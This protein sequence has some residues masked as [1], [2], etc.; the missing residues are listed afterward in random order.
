MPW[1]EKIENVTPISHRYDFF[2][3]I[4]DLL[5]KL[6]RAEDAVVLVNKTSESALPPSQKQLLL[7]WIQIESKTVNISDA[8]RTCEEVSGTLGSHAEYYITREIALCADKIEHYPLSFKLWKE[9]TTSQ[10]FNPDT[11]SLLRAA[12]NTKEYQ[13]II[14]FCTQLRKNEIHERNGYRNEIQA[15]IECHEFNEALNLMVAWLNHKTEDKEMRMNL[16]LLA[17]EIGNEQYIEGDPDKLPAINEVPN[18]EY[19]T[20]VIQSLRQSGNAR[21]AIVYAYE[22][23]RKFPDEMAARHILISTVI[24]SDQ[25][26]TILEKPKEVNL[27]SAVI[28]KA[29]DSDESRAHIIEEGPSPSM[30]RNEYSP[31]HEISKSLLKKKTSDTILLRGTEW[32]ILEIHNKYAYRVSN[33]LKNFNMDFPGNPLL[34]EFKVPTQ[35]DSSTEPQEA[36]GEIR[37]FMQNED[38]RQKTLENLYQKGSLPIVAF[39]QM[40]GKSVLETM[41]YYAASPN[42]NI[43]VSNVSFSYDIALKALSRGCKIVLDETAIATLFMLGLYK[44]LG[45][46]P[47]ELIIPETLVH[48]IRRVAK[49]AAFKRRSSLFLGISNGN[50][51][52]QRV[53]P[54]QHANWINSLEELLVSLQQ[55]CTLEGGKSLLS[56]EPATRKGLIQAFGPANADAIA[57]ASQTGAIYWTDDLLSRALASA[58][59]LQ[60]IWSQ[61]A[62]QYSRDVDKNFTASYNKAQKDMFLWGYDFT[63]VNVE[64]IISICIDAKWNVEDYRLKHVFEF[65]RK[66]GGINKNN[67]YATC[68]LIARIWLI[69]S[70]K[71]KKACEIIILLL[72]KIGRDISGPQIARK[73][74]RHQLKLPDNQK[75]RSLKQMLRTWR[76]NPN[77]A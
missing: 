59:K 3:L 65:I 33:L 76:T 1:C 35:I 37:T 51:T 56:F 14:D 27:A 46:L 20:R 22:L 11:N 60:N 6:D 63:L 21:A 45:R 39:A 18:A 19:G 71:R 68:L 10:D 43:R 73:I 17:S 15:N 77:N 74:Y 64:T 69:K 29:A 23:W 28:Y 26:E 36:L 25:D 47:Y 24:D 9:I 50:L 13:F 44:E 52:I 30:A 54:T 55:H 2:R 53:S 32:S 49:L 72:E 48:E 57:I 42:H 75:I 41:M 5:C 40:M 67:C 31:N 70:L 66:L 12:Q 61:V 16:S 7:L 4:S 62:L 34:K 38:E 58:W 8:K